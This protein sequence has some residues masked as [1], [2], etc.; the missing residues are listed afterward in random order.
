MLRPP[1]KV[2]PA[3]LAEHL[4]RDHPIPMSIPVRA[5]L[6]TEGVMTPEAFA[7]L[8]ALTA[9]AQSRLRLIRHNC[10]DTTV[11][12]AFALQIAELDELLDS[13]RDAEKGGA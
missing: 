8:T 1:A 9:H 3:A 11:K 5:A 7:L 10:E 2:G 13:A 12:A 6:K 4:P